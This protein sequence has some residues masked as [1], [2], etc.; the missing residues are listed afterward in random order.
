MDQKEPV[1]SRIQVGACHP[2]QANRTI[3]EAEIGELADSIR[4]VG[5]LNPIL[6]KEADEGYQIIAGE[7]RWRAHQAIGAEE[8]SAFVYGE[9][10]EVTV[11]ALRVVENEQRSEPTAMDTARELRRIKNIHGLSHEGVAAKTGIPV[12]RVKRYLAIF[13]ASDSLLDA[14]EQH[15]LP[16]KTALAL[17]RYEKEHGEAKLR[18]VLREV[19][20]GQ[21][22]TRDVESLRKKST[23]K[24]SPEESPARAWQRLERRVLELIRKNPAET[25]AGVARLAKAQR[26]ANLSKTG[27]EA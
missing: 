2:H 15:G 12:N 21:I 25:A 11:D 16:T 1:L 19:V 27:A 14:I 17:T 8:I 9:C 6:V 5:L 26:E 24:K 7:R 10:D 23:T 22:T 18:R 20:S 4:A 13:Q 3:R